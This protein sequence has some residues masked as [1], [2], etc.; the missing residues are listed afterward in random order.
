MNISLDCLYEPIIWIPISRT[1]QWHAGLQLVL[2]CSCDMLQ[3]HSTTKSY[4][5]LYVL[6]NWITCS[7]S[8][9]TLLLLPIGWAGIWLYTRLQTINNLRVSLSL[10]RNVAITSLFWPVW[11]WWTLWDCEFPE[12]PRLFFNWTGWPQPSYLMVSLT[13]VSSRRSRTIMSSRA[14][15]TLTIVAWGELWRTSA[16]VKQCKDFSRWTHTNS[17][18]MRVLH[19]SPF[20][21]G[22]TSKHWCTTLRMHSHRKWTNRWITCK[23][24]TTISITPLAASKPTIIIIATKTSHTAIA[25]GMTIRYH[26]E[27]WA[28]I[29]SNSVPLWNLHLE[30]IFV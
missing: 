23:Y 12:C 19:D 30:N 9:A 8:N 4:G 1:W 2:S 28:V 17:F 25:I 24:A 21:I 22:T 10:V 18:P 26:W 20:S 15:W 11:R 14:S 6:N 16:K 13:T 5:L 27:V 29:R 3:L 7:H